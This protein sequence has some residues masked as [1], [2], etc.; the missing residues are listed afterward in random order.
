MQGGLDDDG[1]VDSIT[2]TRFE[3]PPEFSLEGTEYLVIISTKKSSVRF[4]S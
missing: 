1:Q 3:V 4:T 2:S